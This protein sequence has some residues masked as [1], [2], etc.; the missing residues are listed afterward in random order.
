MATLHNADPTPAASQA[1]RGP[2]TGRPE[3]L[4]W[5][6]PGWWV[7]LNG[8]E[9][10]ISRQELVGLWVKQ[11][12]PPS[13]SAFRDP[14]NGWCTDAITAGWVREH[15]TVRAVARL[16]DRQSDPVEDVDGWNQVSALMA[17]YLDSFTRFSLQFSSLA[18]SHKPIKVPKALFPGRTQTAKRH[19]VSSLLDEASRSPVVTA[20]KW[21]MIYDE[22]GGFVFASRANADR[23][24]DD[25][26]PY[27]SAIAAAAMRAY[28]SKLLELVARVDDSDL[29]DEAL[30]DAV[31]ILSSTAEQISE[32]FGDLDEPPRRLT[33]DEVALVREYMK[34]APTRWLAG[35]DSTGA[36]PPRTSEHWPEILSQAVERTGKALR[37][38]VGQDHLH[39]AESPDGVI[40]RSRAE[41]SLAASIFWSSVKFAAWDVRRD[42]VRE[43]ARADTPMV[44]SRDRRTATNTERPSRQ[45]S[46][47]DLTS[48]LEYLRRTPLRE[49]KA[50]DVDYRGPDECWERS[51][52]ADFFALARGQAAT[53]P[54]S[55]RSIGPAVRT[56]ALH[57]FDAEDPVDTLR[58]T[59][60]ESA[61]LVAA[62]VLESVNAARF[63]ADPRSR[64]PQPIARRTTEAISAYNRRITM[65][66]TATS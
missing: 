21:A 59:D 51:V 12:P 15:Y 6:V 28:G 46:E 48:A 1:H 32:K 36:P 25:P 42:I 27:R 29:L 43:S 47:F 39:F 20:V 44:P 64:M 55:T 37:R 19:A 26:E 54:S 10:Q 62:L 33:T 9:S 65:T 57:R 3:H 58:A 63:D 18:K 56:Y 45:G 14:L 49:F 2:A 60:E 11:P 17:D 23:F 7:P 22:E 66:G 53:L 4:N 35:E 38:A 5:V 30:R 52:A 41:R 40:L 24:L 31:D 34:T 13:G 50:V 16:K 61:A 8:D